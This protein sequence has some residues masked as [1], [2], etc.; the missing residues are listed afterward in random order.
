MGNGRVRLYTARRFAPRARPVLLALPLLSLLSGCL[1]S[2]PTD[3]EAPNEGEVAV[4]QQPLLGSVFSDPFAITCPQ[5]TFDWMQEFMPTARAVARSSAFVECMDKSI[6]DGQLMLQLAGKNNIFAYQNGPYMPCDGSS[7]GSCSEG[8]DGCPPGTTWGVDCC[9]G[10]GAPGTWWDNADAISGDPVQNQVARMLSVSVSPNRLMIS[11][12]AEPSVG[13]A[14]GTQIGFYDLFDIEAFR[15]WAYGGDPAFGAALTWHEVM[16]VHDY[17]HG[18]HFDNNAPELAAYCGGQQYVDEGF[19]PTQ[20]A[21]GIVGSCIEEVMEQSEA[22][23]SD[24]ECDAGE[25]AVLANLQTLAFPVPFTPEPQN[26]GWCQCVPDTYGI[27]PVAGPGEPVVYVEENESGDRFGQAFAAGDFDGDGFDDLAVGAPGEDQ[28]AGAVYLFRGT[29][30]GLRYWKRIV[31]TQWGFASEPGDELG[32]S[33]AA[34]DLNGD[35]AADLVVGVPGEN[36]YG[37]ALAFPGSLPDWTSSPKQEGGL[38]LSAYVRLRQSVGGLGSNDAGDRFGQSLAIG[39]FGPDNGAL[40]VAVGA[41]FEAEDGVRGG[42]VF[43][44]DFAATSNPKTLSRTG[45]ARIVQGMGTGAHQVNDEFG[46]ALVAGNFDTNSYDELIVGAPGEAGSRGVIFRADY[47]SSSGW[48]LTAVSHQGAGTFSRFGQSLAQGNLFGTSSEEIAVGAPFYGWVGRVSIFSTTSSG[49]THRQNLDFSGGGFA[50]RFGW[51]LAMA[52]WDGSGRPD[53]VVGR[54]G[55]TS[56]GVAGAG[57]AH[58][59]RGQSTSNSV[60]FWATRRQQF[61]YSPS[62]SD[63]ALPGETLFAGEDYG[64]AVAAGDFNGDGLPE[65]VIGSPGDIAMYGTGASAGAMF[66]YDGFWL[67][68]LGKYDQVTQRFGNG[69]PIFK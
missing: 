33:L 42:G 19:G 67:D 21:T 22:F 64:A 27:G 62:V 8:Q 44:F 4:A 7:A 12:T 5:E 57:E 30:T 20:A 43:I 39:K 69:S 28:G 53:L 48:Q 31:Q 58:F 36:G 59:Y 3:G 38:V 17:H 51:S 23:C 41:P 49:L 47:G 56:G 68:D 29:R 9:A 35:G 37:Y 10:P 45:F 61:I 16:H 66:Y 13:G 46:A 25:T 32:Y 1:A 50:D 18:L 55:A 2:A 26:G 60:A 34:G 24:V 40:D 14:G 54:P 65:A 15:F 52:D 11:C 63:S 6:R